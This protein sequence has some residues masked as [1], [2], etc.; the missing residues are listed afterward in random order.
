VPTSV[1]LAVL[2]AA[3]LLALA[4]AL[5][6]RYDATERL[7]AERASSTARVLDRRRR[8]RTVPGSVPVNLSRAPTESTAGERPTAP[9]APGDRERRSSVRVPWRG[10]RGRKSSGGSARPAGSAPDG[11]DRQD[12]TELGDAVEG[13][14]RRVTPRNAAAD[15]RWWQRRHRRVFAILVVLCLLEAAGVAA[16]GPGFLVG[17]TVSGLL[18]GWYVAALR[19]RVVVRQR[20][21]TRWRMVAAQ[22]RAA[23]AA[24]RRRNA[25]KRRRIAEA[26]RHAQ[27]LTRRRAAELAALRAEGVRHGGEDAEP[28]A[29][30]LRGQSYQARAANF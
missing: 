21:L 16:I 24:E 3:G 28:G 20:E 4:P 1:L 5:V 25:E 7:D 19:R 15:R 9:P 18:L 23:A 30:G 11:P 29:P 14:D 8:R 22:R 2:V 12:P 17:F 10:P 13:R 6:R 26:R 27:E